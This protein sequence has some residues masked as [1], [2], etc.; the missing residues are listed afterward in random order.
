MTKVIQCGIKEVVYMSDKYAMTESTIA[1]KK[2]FDMAGVA[3]R[4]F[5]AKGRKITLNL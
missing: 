5:E 4:P 2:M 1:S 3:Y